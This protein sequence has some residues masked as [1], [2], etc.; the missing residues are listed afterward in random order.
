MQSDD[1]GLRVAGRGLRATALAVCCLLPGVLAFFYFRDN[2]S[3][4]YPIKVLSQ[5][6]WRAG[7]IPFWNFADGG[8]QPLAGNPN[9]LSFYPD[10]VLYLFLPAHVAFNLHFLLHLIGGWLAMRALTRS[11]A[12]AWM[13]VLSGAAISATAFYNMVTAIALIPLALLAVQRRS[14]L[15]LGCAFGLLALAGEPVTIAGTAIAVLIV[16]RMRIRDWAL[17]ALVALVI[18]SPQLIAW[19]EVASEVERAHG[20]SARTVLNASLEP[21]RIAEMVVGPIFPH[22]DPRLFLSLFIGIIAVPALMQRSRYVIAAAVLL[23]F[24]L[25]RFNPIVAWAAEFVRIARFPEKLAIPLTVAIVVLAANLLQRSRAWQSVTLI[26]LA[27]WAIVTLPI[28]WFAPYRVAPQRPMRIYATPLPGGQDPSRDDYRRRAARLDPLF[29]ATA[30]LRYAVDRS[31]D[32]MFS[33]ASRIAAERF[34][35]THDAKWLRMAGCA[36]VPGAL[37]RA[38]IVPRT[39]EAH[40]PVRAIEDPSFDEHAAAVAPIAFASAPGARVTRVVE[41]PQSLE[42]GLASAGPALLFVNET[43]FRAWDAGN[44]KTLPLDLDRLGVL[45]PAGTTT[46]TLRF[47]RH[48]AAV[49]IAWIASWLLLL[50]VEPLDRRTRKVERS[51][52]DDAARG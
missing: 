39:V 48:H 38:W 16:G 40:D 2:F 4:H 26:P 27:A 47:G 37:P 45:V 8:G 15:W 32:G 25:G 19:S 31:P 43:Y 5:G 49:V 9:T 17:A 52:D 33:L 41:H 7:A 35:T 6:I 12:A 42:I 23:F 29:G 11:R 50:L 34:A 14:A 46:V 30:G 10:N 28:D 18:A 21:L 13:Y 24:A 51:G 22:H 44:L 1:L 3:T 20:Y 36:N